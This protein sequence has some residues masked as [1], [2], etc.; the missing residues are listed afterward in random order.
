MI[1][2]VNEVI[3]QRTIILIMSCLMLSA[4]LYSSAIAEDKPNEMMQKMM[5]M[6]KANFEKSLENGEELYGDSSLGTTGLT[7]TSCHPRG[8]TAGGRAEMEHKGMIMR[9]KIPTLK[10]AAASFPAPRGPEQKVVSLKGMN[11]LCIKSFL[12]GKPLDENSQD[13]T[14]L[15][16]YVSTFGKN[17]P[18]TP[19]GKM[20]YKK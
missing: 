2:E 14:D 13:A 9:P 17:A 1:V 8:G 15:A 20:K 7:C 6:G 3:K 11:N 16:N 19:N 5:K 10:E 4:G 18:L 12:K